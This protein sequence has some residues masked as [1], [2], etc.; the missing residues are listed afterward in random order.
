M[1]LRRDFSKVGMD[2]PLNKKEKAEFAAFERAEKR[3]ER[4]EF[5]RSAGLDPRPPRSQG[6]AVKFSREIEERLNRAV[7]AEDFE[8]AAALR[9]ELEKRKGQN[10]AT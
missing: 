4:D 10:G 5:L 9:D 3:R 7:A 6:K 2:L 1:L 8:R